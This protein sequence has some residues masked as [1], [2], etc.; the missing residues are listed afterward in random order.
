MS[1]KDSIECIVLEKEVTK[2]EEIILDLK[3]KLIRSHEETEQIRTAFRDYME[4]RES[5]L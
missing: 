3:E 5:V 1:W 2:L 4:Y